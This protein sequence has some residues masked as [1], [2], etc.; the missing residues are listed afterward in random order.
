MN[1]GSFYDKN[2]MNSV[3]QLTSISSMIRIIFQL[4]AHFELKFTFREI[5]FSTCKDTKNPTPY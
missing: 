4:S 1:I 5:I 3:P 2:D